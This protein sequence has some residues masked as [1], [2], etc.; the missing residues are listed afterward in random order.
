M[1]GGG[2]R[3]GWL[4]AKDTAPAMTTRI[5]EN[6]NYTSVRNRLAGRVTVEAAGTVVGGRLPHRRQVRLIFP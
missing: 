3:A 5:G 2:Q 4:V 6:F 1:T